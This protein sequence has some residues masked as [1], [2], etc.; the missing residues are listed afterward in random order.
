MNLWRRGGRFTFQKRIPSDLVPRLGASPARLALPACG[1]REAR[2]TAALLGGLAEAVFD[3][4]RLEMEFGDDPRE[5][6]IEE[7]EEALRT[8]EE[9]RRIEVELVERRCLMERLHEQRD[10]HERLEKLEQPLARIKAG[11]AQVRIRSGV[12]SEV[13]AMLA[14]LQEQVSSLANN[15]SQQQPLPHLSESYAK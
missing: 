3:Q 13:G 8:S 4:L 1:V 15:G 11:L 14:A 2:R 9:L 7:L 6:L 5:R 12:P 10:M